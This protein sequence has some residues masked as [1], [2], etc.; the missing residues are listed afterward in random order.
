MKHMEK[1]TDENYTKMLHVALKKILE[2]ASHK[3]AVIWPLTFQCWVNTY[4]HLLSADTE[5]CVEDLPRAMGD[6]DG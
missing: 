5:C 4:I 1:K 3:I 6:W 2:A